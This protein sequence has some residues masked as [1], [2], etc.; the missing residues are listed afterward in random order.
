M[1]RRNTVSLELNPATYLAEYVHVTQIWNGV[2][3][4]YKTA[5]HALDGICIVPI[6]QIGIKL[7][8]HELTY[9]VKL[10]Y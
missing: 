9:S 3:K 6:S 4:L 7:Y 1:D 5:R 8:W 10:L 2:L